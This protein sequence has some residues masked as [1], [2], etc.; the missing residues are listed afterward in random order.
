MFKDDIQETLDII[1]ERKDYI[2]DWTYNKNQRYRFMFDT[3]LGTFRYSSA[4]DVINL[5]E[6]LKKLKLNS[7][8]ECHNLSFVLAVRFPKKCTAVTG[9]IYGE[10]KEQE[11]YHSW[12]EIEDDDAVI[13]GARNLFMPRDDYYRLFVNPD[14]LINKIPQE[15]L[16]ELEG[17]GIDKIAYL[18]YRYMELEDSLGVRNTKKKVK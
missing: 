14:A 9:I 1:K 4:R 12:I 13:D 18:L 5:D 2:Q 16:Q 7:D 3:T 8:G 17:T 15:K 6:V 11:N 10:W